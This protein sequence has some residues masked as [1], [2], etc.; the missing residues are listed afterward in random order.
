MLATLTSPNVWPIIMLG[1]ACIILAAVIFDDFHH[2][3]W[4]D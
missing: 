2:T 4:D 1:F 3:D